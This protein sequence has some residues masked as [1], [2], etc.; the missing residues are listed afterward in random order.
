MLIVYPTA[1]GCGR[2]F[3]ALVCIRTPECVTKHQ[4]PPAPRYPGPPKPGIPATPGPGLVGY[5]APAC[6]PAGL[7]VSCL[8]ELSAI[9]F[10]WQL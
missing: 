1:S 8:T 7:P 9:I 2:N 6:P 4:V 10:R 5:R 3:E